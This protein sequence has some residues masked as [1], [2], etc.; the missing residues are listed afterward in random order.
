[1]YYSATA[2][3][4]QADQEMLSLGWEK[5]DICHGSGIGVLDGDA[6]SHTLRLLSLCSV[7]VQIDMCARAHTHT[8]THEH[9]HTHTHI[10][11]PHIGACRPA[12]HQKA[13]QWYVA[14]QTPPTS[15][16]MMG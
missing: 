6:F 10:H 13:Q 8:N 12:P 7:S 5:G 15:I 9:A 1:M 2:A 16:H 11:T 4:K 14:F 3:T